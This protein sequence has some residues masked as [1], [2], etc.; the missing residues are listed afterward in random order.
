[1]HHGSLGKQS[2]AQKYLLSRET[3]HAYTNT[4]ALIAEGKVEEAGGGMAMDKLEII[5]QDRSVLQNPLCA[6]TF[7]NQLMQKCTT[8][9][10][11]GSDTKNLPKQM[12]S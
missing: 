10:D 5:L 7:F 9:A 4:K 2:T 12:L 8:V 1:M 11:E 6:S 3:T